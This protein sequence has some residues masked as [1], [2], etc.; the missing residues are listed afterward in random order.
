MQ[1]GPH[2]GKTISTRYFNNARFANPFYEFVH[3]AAGFTDYATIR[4]DQASLEALLTNSETMAE[5]LTEGLKVK[6]ATV[7]KNKDSRHGNN[8]A[9][10][11]GGVSTNSIERRGRIPVAFKTIVDAESTI[12]RGEFGEALGV[13][14]ELFLRRAPSG[15]E[16]EHYW[17]EVFG[18]NAPLGN[19]MALQAVLIYITLSPRVRLPHGDRHGRAGRATGA[20]SSPPTSWS[21]RSTTPSTTARPSGSTS[22]RPSTHTPRRGCRSSRRPSPTATPSTAG[23]AG[24]SSRCAPA[25][26]R[27]ARTSGAPCAAT[28]TRRSGTRT[29]TTTPR[30]SPTRGSCSFSANTSATTRP[31]RS[32]KTPTSSRGSTA[33]NSSTN[34]RRT[35]WFTT[36][37]RSCCTSSKRT[38]TCS[39][40]C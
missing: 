17:T 27:R 18:K 10:F 8:E 33:S 14:F 23:T 40:N 16:V 34:T 3:H 5:I 36:R 26:W 35:A 11:V 25:S 13:A 39:A 7:I 15:P 6:V 21:T 31:P 9:G 19:K 4:A 2:K 32:S 12:S 37:T 38:G 30:R 28:W 29:R 20:V 1:R 22:S 24:W